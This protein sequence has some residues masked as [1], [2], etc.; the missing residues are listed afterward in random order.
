MGAVTEDSDPDV[1][2]AV[3]VDAVAALEAWGGA[4][5]LF[6]SLAVGAYVDHPPAEDVDVFVGDEDVDDAVAALA[7]AGFRPGERRDWLRKAHREG[8]LVDLIIEVRGGIRLDRELLSH[9]RRGTVRPGVEAPIPAPEDLVV[10]EA[11]S[12][13]P[14]T[15]EHWF[16]AAKLVAGTEIDWRYLASRARLA[17]LRVASLLL[18]CRSDGVDVPD[19][20]LGSVLPS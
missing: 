2:G 1:F 3:L 14:E 12:S 16:T 7:R 4:H 6:G 13:H 17:P 8:V 5:A 11:A 10:I 20:I 15:P 9:L 19:D 18:Y